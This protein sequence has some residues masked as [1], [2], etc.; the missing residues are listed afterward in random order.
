VHDV[1]QAFAN[2]FVEEIGM[3]RT[4]PHPARPDFKMLAN[5]LKIDGERPAQAVCSP[6]GGDNAALLG[7]S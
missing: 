2:P 1:G 3:V 6:L 5:P 7:D 4:V